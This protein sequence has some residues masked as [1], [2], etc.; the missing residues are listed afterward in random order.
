[1]NRAP[2]G[3]ALCLGALVAAAALRAQQPQG[4]V[5]QLAVTAVADRSVYLDRGRDAGLRVGTLVRL[6]PPGA[7]F[8]EVEVRSASSSSARAELPPGVPEPPI[9][10]RGEANVPAAVAAP[11]PTPSAVPAARRVPD[12]PPWVRQDGAR[13]DDQPLLV[14]TFNQRPE[15]RPATLDGRLFA[16]GQWTM[17]RGDQRD[18]DYLLLRSG[19]R[20]DAT[21]FLGAA[22]RFR[23]SG[24]IDDRRVM[25]PDAADRD[26]RNARIDYASVAFGTE[27]WAPTGFE[28]GRFYSS[29]LPDIGLF[30]G[31]EV[32]RRGLGG[33]S[34]GGGIGAYPRPYPARDTGADVGGHAFFEY[35]SDER[36]SFGGVIG[37]QKTW[38]E[39]APDRDLL[40]LRAD[41]RPSDRSSLYG[42]AK[43]DYYTGSDDLKGSGVELTELMLQARWNGPV[44]GA[45]VGVSHFAWPQLKRVEYQ[46]LPVELVRDGHVDRLSLSGSAKVADRV[47]VRPRADVWADQDRN[48]TSFGV[49]AEWWQAFSQRSAVTLSLFQSDGGYSSGPGLRLGYR[50]RLGDGSWSLSYRW[51][52][53]ELGGLV[54]GAES[55]TRQSVEGNLA[56]PVGDRCDLDLDLSHAFGDGEDA[57]SFGFYLQWRF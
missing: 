33:V 18:S 53:Y 5:V 57:T 25:L 7:D 16:T 38:H 17:D 12:H 28:I 35:V 13:S 43:L 4:D 32:V 15:D 46:L 30:D 42:S 37:L 3:F 31:I 1:M 20:G 26:D 22:E 27:Q 9:G 19:V 24:E 47:T 40:I 11:S 10:T 6:F 39:G 54:S 51:H 21:N 44:W 36:R 34:F 45:G 56:L 29:H 48:G 49:D 14:P 55:Y 41:A 50:D 2:R 8:V 23:F 52:R